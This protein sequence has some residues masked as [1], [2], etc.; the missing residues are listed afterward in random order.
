[1]LAEKGRPVCQVDL[2][3]DVPDAVEALLRNL[4]TPDGDPWRA[5]NPRGGIPMWV[6]CPPGAS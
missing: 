3:H 6:H 5:S 2:L 4:A 1:M